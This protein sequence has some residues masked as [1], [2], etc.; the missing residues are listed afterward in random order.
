MSKQIEWY[1]A[2]EG[3]AQEVLKAAKGD[4]D[5]QDWQRYEVKNAVDKLTVP[6]LR[7]VSEQLDLELGRLEELLGFVKFAKSAIRK[8]SGL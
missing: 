1:T 6:E 2:L 7:E 5:R 3:P 8:E 4:S